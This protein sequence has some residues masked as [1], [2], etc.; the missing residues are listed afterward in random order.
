MSGYTPGRL[1]WRHLDQEQAQQLW[2]ELIDW[3]G[4]VLPKLTRG[5]R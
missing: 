3:V 5:A 1:S 2:D 4:P